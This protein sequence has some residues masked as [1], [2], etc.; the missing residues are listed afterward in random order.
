VFVKRF[1]KKVIHNAW[2][3]ALLG[4][5]RLNSITNTKIATG[6]AIAA[7]IIIP[8][9]SNISLVSLFILQYTT[10][11]RVCQAVFSLFFLALILAL[12]LASRLQKFI[13]FFFIL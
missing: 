3:G 6:T 13:L 8:V 11:S 12:I 5:Y 4:H 10:L 1:I 9:I 2:G 7:A